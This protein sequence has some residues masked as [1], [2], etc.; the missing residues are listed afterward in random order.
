MD[1]MAEILER[2]RAYGRSLRE[3]LVGTS[4]TNDAAGAMQLC[5]NGADEFCWG[6]VWS[7]PAMSHKTRAALALAMC[8]AQSQLE[9]VKECTRIALRTGW[10]APEI[11]EIL[12]HVQCYAGLYPS[13]ESAKAAS[14][15][16]KELAPEFVAP[17]PR[18]TAQEEAGLPGPHDHVRPMSE[19]ARAGLRIRR[20]VLGSN[21]I[22]RW[23]AETIKDP[24]IMMFFDMT[25]EYCFGTVWARNVLDYRIR[26]MLCLVINACRGLS[27]AVKRHIRSAVEVGMSKEDVGEVFLHVYAYAGV[28]CS[29]NGFMTANEVFAELAREGVIVREKRSSGDPPL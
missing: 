17:R 13:L 25:H 19:L 7:R 1:S 28:Y 18:A 20:E 8:A 10:S 15:V 9:G 3:E 12:F 6:A 14:E 23:M 26:S 11:A 4:Q 24:F 29:L 5:R 27:G 16:I 2:R 21:D 22:D